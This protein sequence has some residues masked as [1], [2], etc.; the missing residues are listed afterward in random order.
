MIC[1][2]FGGCFKAVFINSQ[3]FTIFASPLAS[4]L[5]WLQLGIW[6]E[7]QWEPALPPPEPPPGLG[8]VPQHESYKPPWDRW[9][10]MNW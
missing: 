2:H 4:K 1:T 9:V 6:G 7:L 10:G 3:I 5:S 8:T